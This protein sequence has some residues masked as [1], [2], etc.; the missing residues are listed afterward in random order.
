MKKEMG[1]LGRG[2]QTL[3]RS[4]DTPP[5]GTESRGVPCPRCISLWHRKHPG[6]GGGAC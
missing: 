3:S 1:R 6:A 2:E 5:V 4:K